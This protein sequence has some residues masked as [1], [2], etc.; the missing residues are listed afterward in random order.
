MRRLIFPII[1]LLW[2]AMSVCG[3]PLDKPVVSEHLT[4]KD[5]LSNNFVTDIVQ[6]RQGFLWIGTESGLNRFDGENFTT[7]SIRNSNLIG[8]AIEC[9]YYDRKHD[10]LWIGTKKGLNILDCATR[11][12]KSLKLPDSVR[13]NNITDI[14]GSADGGIW[15]VNHYDNIIHYNPETSAYRV[16]GPGNTQ[17]LPGSYLSVTEG[18]DNVLY[19]GH[20]NEGL[21]VLNL[22][23]GKLR[24]YRNDRDNPFSLP[25]SGV[26]CIHIDHYGNVWVGTNQGL[27]LF[28]S[29]SERFVRF[30]HNPADPYSPIGNHI[31]SIMEMNDSTLWIS[32]DMGGVSILDL[33]NLTF[34]NPEHLQFVNLKAAAGEG[35]SISSPDIRALFQDSF[36]NIWIGNYGS[37]IDFVNHTHPVFNIYPYGNPGES[38]GSSKPVWGIYED[39][40]GVVWLGGINNVA[41]V[42]EGKVLRTYD[43]SDFLPSALSHVNVIHRYKGRLMLGIYDGGALS[44]EERS[45]KVERIMP[46]SLS[47]VNTFCDTPD[48]RLLI[49]VKD[50]LYEYDGNSYRKLKAVSDLI[51]NQTPN[52]IV[53]DNQGK[54]WIGSYG[55]GVY[56]FDKGMKPV[57]RLDSSEGFVSNAVTQIFKD[58]KGGLWIAGQDGLAYVKDTRHPKKYVNYGYDN[59]LEDIHIRAIQEDRRGDIW[60]AHN[61]GLTRYNRDTGR[62]ENYDYNDGLPQSNFLDRAVALLSDGRLC[63]GSFNGICVFSPDNLSH[64]GKV[65]PVQIVEC[66][67]INS[68]TGDTAD[69]ILIPG[70]DG[71]I[72]LP[73]NHNSVR[74]MY[75]VPDFAQSRLVEY[76]YMV[77]GIDKNW[78]PTRGENHAIFRNLPPGHYTFKVRA[79]LKN[80]DWDDASVAEMK[81]T[82]KPPVWLTWWAKLIYLVVIAAAIYFCVRYYKRRLMLKNSLELERRKSIDEKELND[83]R[84]RFYTNITQ[85]LRT[86]LTLILGPLEDLVS[87]DMMPDLYKKK[88][89][90]IHESTLRLL[91]LINQILEFRKTETQ[92]RKLTVGKGDI[93]SLVMEIGLRYKEL[94]RNDKV[95]FDID[96]HKMAKDIYFDN[97]VVTTVLNNL[98]SNAVKYTPSGR[99]ALTL[100]EVRENDSDYVEICVADTGYGIES[101]ALPH[102]FDRYY[103]AKGKH[104]A[105]GT[106]IGLALVKSLSDLHEGQLT[107]ESKPGVGTTFRFLLLRD[108]TYPA[109]L[110]KEFEDKAENGN[111][112][113][114]RPETESGDDLKPMVLVVEDNESIRDYIQSSL[115]DRF[116]V[117]VAEDGKEGLEIARKEIPDIVISDI[118]M[119]VMDG[120]ELCRHIKSDISTS[121]IPVVLLT[122]KDSI[123]DKEEGYDSGADSYLTKPF[124]AR[125]LISRINNI[126]ESRK[127]LAALIAS[128]INGNLGRGTTDVSKP[129][130]V[131]EA[132]LC[133]SKLDEKFLHRFTAIVEENLNNGSLDMTF[134]R[135]ALNMSHSTLYRKIKSLTG[136]SGNEFIRKIKLKHGY[137]LLKDGNNVTEAAYA[138]GFG[139]VKHFRNSF[140]DEYGMTPSQFLKDLKTPKG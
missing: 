127:L 132:P 57:A 113:A 38:T 99:I 93:A 136:M 2:L 96:V 63:F 91:N 128:N 121:H 85:E 24:N 21:S 83:E 52:G 137:E 94:N 70:S 139:D 87:D 102:I 81:I 59:G 130:K 95:K 58:S 4:I 112:P 119:P 106:G 43:L 41:A 124:S 71:E 37:G 40:D 65:V 18:A 115:D 50:G 97:D 68:H 3:K 131:P 11:E 10:S 20:A 80:Q 14:T 19:I 135:D 51:F 84:L 31:H 60:F 103:Q 30:L 8:N 108:N 45:G 92:N 69:E 47:H 28:D 61:S 105:S 39:T 88:V 1:T 62:F 98:L 118:M 67:G 110:H 46:A 15:I 122:A 125:L 138:C 5:G 114:S 36:G 107:V 44:I 126:L 17:G 74:V 117:L 13:I 66:Q 42:R 78:I 34:R 86:P 33:R 73:Y 49:G 134:L 101:D 89:R 32:S 129:V 12:I 104:Q 23:T 7:F 29:V 9:L 120:I 22:R 79:R 35:K 75:A 48:G 72:V 27:A 123:G 56:V 116:R 111:V 140:R 133:L 26:A 25:G 100:N 54:M 82:V 77:E 16:Y 90:I 76:A 6:D 109:A 53:F 55:L 64:T